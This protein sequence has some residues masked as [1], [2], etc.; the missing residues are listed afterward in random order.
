MPKQ[1]ELIGNRFGDL[2][3]LE[4][5]GI[6]NGGNRYW[7]CECVCGNKIKASSNRLISG[8]KTHCGCKS[9]SKKNLVNQKFGKLTVLRRVGYQGNNAVW[10]CKCECGQKITECGPFL[11]KGTTTSCGCSGHGPSLLASN[12]FNLQIP[13]LER[14]PEFYLPTPEEM[15]KIDKKLL[16]LDLERKG[17]YAKKI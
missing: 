14:K 5:L 6:R 3:V 10:L 15:E 2:L 8:L 9:T 16:L 1:F 12:F 11:R 13:N 17:Y 4:Y 7:L